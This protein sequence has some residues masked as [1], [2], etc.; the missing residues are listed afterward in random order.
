M[1]TAH[2]SPQ[3]NAFAE[4]WVCAVR[5]ELLDSTIIWNERQLW[6]LLV[7]YLEHY[8]EYRPHRSLDQR[9]PWSSPAS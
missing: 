5:Q 8:N 6:R 9:A 4:R 3:A 7:Q 1:G 2:Y